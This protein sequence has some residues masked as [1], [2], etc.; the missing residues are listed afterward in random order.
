MCEVIKNEGEN[1]NSSSSYGNKYLTI[2]FK[3]NIFIYYLKEYV[4]FCVATVIKKKL[5][6]INNSYEF[7]TILLCKNYLLVHF[8]SI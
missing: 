3:Y 8:F 7:K 2:E 6:T 5:I 1:E 4:N